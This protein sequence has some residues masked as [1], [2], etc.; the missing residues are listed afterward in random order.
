MKLY[1]LTSLIAV[2]LLISGCTN[3]NQEPVDDKTKGQVTTNMK[4][5]LNDTKKE[6]GY[7]ITFNY[8]DD[9]FK[10]SAKTYNDDL[11]MLSFGAALAATT[12]EQAASFYLNMGYDN[13]VASPDYAAPDGESVEYYFAHKHIDDFEL[14]AV[15]SVGFKYGAEWDNNLLLGSNGD[16][17]G[18]D[19][20]SEKMYT[21]LKTY[22]QDNYA[23]KTVKV[24]AAGYS[25]AGGLANVLSYKILSKNE[26]G[27]TQDTLYTYTFEAPRGLTEEH[28]IAY[29]NVFNF[30]NKCDLV[31][32]VAPEAWGLYRCG[33]D[34]EIYSASVDQLVYD[35]DN[36]IILP[37]F[38]CDESDPYQTFPE[39]V[40]WALGKLME[41]A[42][43]DSP[44]LIPYEIDTR[45]HYVQ[46]EQETLRYVVPLF[47]S[48]SDEQL[49]ALITHVKSLPMLDLFALLGDGGGEK[50]YEILSTFFNGQAITYDATKLHD[51][52]INLQAFVV[53]GHPI[54]VAFL[55]NDSAKRSL[56]MH[57]P[58]VAYALTKEAHIY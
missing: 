45:A 3:K 31:T 19:Q 29:E 7:D 27:I 25:R 47:M 6:T 23:N 56:Y 17:V 14:V 40:D 50:L 10:Q 16:H 46:N 30:V 2:A 13:A 36:Q 28:A 32:K 33:V 44:E 38:S 58:E 51:A 42:A 21:A 34:V 48:M 15:A 20:A 5:Y 55:T 53:K 43:E 11:K 41:P 22:I 52:C 35:F 4:A 39:F 9:Y 8:N 18:F 26:L 1:K 12:V 49:D 37:Q 54:L 24:W 57:M